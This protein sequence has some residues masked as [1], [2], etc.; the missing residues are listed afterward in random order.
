M[1]SVFALIFSLVH[2][3]LFTYLPRIS[4]SHY[5]SFLSSHSFCR[6]HS[7]LNAARFTNYSYA[8]KMETAF[9]IYECL[10][11]TYSKFHRLVICLNRFG[12]PQTSTTSCILTW[13]HLLLHLIGL[14]AVIW[15]YVYDIVGVFIFFWLFYDGNSSAWFNRLM[16]LFSSGDESKLREIV[17]FSIACSPSH[18]IYITVSLNSHTLTKVKRSNHIENMSDYIV[19]LMQNVN[20]D[21]YANDETNASE[22]QTICTFFTFA[23]HAI[24]TFNLSAFWDWLGKCMYC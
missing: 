17:G 6:I 11:F 13:V 5:H 3:T 19:Q 24:T 16:I 21:Y 20:Y 18:T 12:L 9:V 14:L 7:R 10:C 1:C 2:W 4:L 8:I 15:F 23:L 22:V